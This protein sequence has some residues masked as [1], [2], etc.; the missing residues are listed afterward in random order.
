MNRQEAG[1][2]FRPRIVSCSTV[3]PNTYEAPG[4]QGVDGP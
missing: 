1:F 2:F 4:R 3:P